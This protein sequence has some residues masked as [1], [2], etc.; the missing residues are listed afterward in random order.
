MKIPPNTEKETLQNAFLKHKILL[1][2]TTKCIS[3]LLTGMNKQTE[4]YS[5]D[6]FQVSGT[7]DTG[8]VISGLPWMFICQLYLPYIYAVLLWTDTLL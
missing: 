2:A 6:V 1:P 8:Y 7:L 5:L 3:R 4:K